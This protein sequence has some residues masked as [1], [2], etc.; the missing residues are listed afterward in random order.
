MDKPTSKSIDL[1]E[2]MMDEDNPLFMYVA[3]IIGRTMELNYHCVKEVMDEFR[4]EFVA[5]GKG[6]AF[7][8]LEGKLDEVFLD[9]FNEEGK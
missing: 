1:A 8:N 9:F 7:K 6:E 3:V 5:A 4:E 2:G